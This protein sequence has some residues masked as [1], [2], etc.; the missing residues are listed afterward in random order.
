MTSPRKAKGDRAELEIAGILRDELGYPVRRM[1]GA[2]RLDDVGDLVGIPDTT[3]Q[4]ADWADALRAIRE[5]PLA[6][7]AQRFNA[8]TTHAVT[9]VRLRGGLWRAVLTP[10]QWADTMRE[11]LA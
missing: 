6:V 10:E 7:E 8:G 5:K 1:L 2:G 9:F 11:A 3:I 4:V